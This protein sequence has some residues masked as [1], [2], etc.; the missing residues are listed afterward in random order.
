[1]WSA[2]GVS[3]DSIML[4]DKS[5]VLGEYQF[6][7]S[8]DVTYQASLPTQGKPLL[9]SKLSSVFSDPKSHNETLEHEDEV[10][11][12]EHASKLQS[13]QNEERIGVSDI[14]DLCAQRLH[15]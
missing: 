3:D 5:R 13:D 11:E 10:E 7:T 8:R 2:K 4:V 6:S 15:R 14:L 9:E 12:A 1:M